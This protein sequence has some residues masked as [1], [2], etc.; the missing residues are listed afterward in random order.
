M[1]LIQILAKDTCDITKNASRTYPTSV[2]IF[3]SF[4]SIHLLQPLYHYL[5]ISKR[6]QKDTIIALTSTLTSHDQSSYIVEMRI[7]CILPGLSSLQTFWIYSRSSSIW[8]IKENNGSVLQ[9]SWK[10]PLEFIL[11]FV[12]LLLIMTMWSPKGNLL[13]SCLC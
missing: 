11:K 1:V 3:I 9:F 5:F 10:K 12:N 7:T 4:L 2:Y 8:D 13:N 6:L